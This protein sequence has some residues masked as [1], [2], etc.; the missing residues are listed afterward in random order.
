MNKLFLKGLF[1]A[2]ASMF[3][4]MVYLVFVIFSDHQTYS[5]DSF[6]THL[7][8]PNALSSLSE[9]CENSP[10]FVYSSADGP[11][12]AIVTM[13][14]EISMIDFEQQM[15]AIGFQKVN[16]KLY[17]AREAQ[18][19]ITTAPNGQKVNLVVFIESI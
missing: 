8:T 6:L 1:F 2:L 18:I 13:R 5:S 16:D 14:C 3:A 9:R 19:E 10:V 7:L 4:F 11:K 17:E 12:P 15:N